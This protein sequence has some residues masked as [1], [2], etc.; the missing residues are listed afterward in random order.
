MKSDPSASISNRVA[1]CYTDL[2]LIALKWLIHKTYNVEMNI[3]R[4]EVPRFDA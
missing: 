1:F 3:V 2:R 4:L